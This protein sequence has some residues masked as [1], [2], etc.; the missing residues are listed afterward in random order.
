MVP[1]TSSIT[2]ALGA[3][4]GEPGR[5]DETPPSNGLDAMT[6]SVEMGSAMGMQYLEMQYKFQLAS[7]NYGAISNMM[8]ARYE[9]VKKSL[10]G[11]R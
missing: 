5:E 6:N 11:V 3:F 7:T 4:D 9:T 10:D 2:S 1:S 8:K